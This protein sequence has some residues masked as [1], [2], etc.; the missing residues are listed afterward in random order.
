MSKRCDPKLPSKEDRGLLR[1]SS[2]LQDPPCTF[3]R[4]GRAL[5]QS[6]RAFL[7]TVPRG[8]RRDLERTFL[9]C[10][11]NK[12]GHLRPPGVSKAVQRNNALVLVGFDAQGATSTTKLGIDLLLDGRPAPNFEDSPRRS[13]R[14]RVR[15]SR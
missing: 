14:S 4:Q 9:I 3:F 12:A 10:A 8:V 2:G 5:I 6:I 11:T 7:V 13:Q 15:G 1:Y